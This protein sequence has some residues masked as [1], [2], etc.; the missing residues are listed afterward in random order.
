[1]DAR[2]ALD[3]LA[4]LLGVARSYVDGLGRT[5]QVPPETLSAICRSMGMPMEGP[6]DAPAALAHL[7][8]E[9]AAGPRIPSVIVAWE[10]VLPR[11]PLRTLAPVRAWIECDDGPRVPLE[12]LAGTLALRA[13]RLPIGR[14]TLHVT[15]GDTEA[16]AP[17]L[18]APRLGWRP[19]RSRRRWGVATHVAALRSRRSGAIGD[20]D[21]LE[22]VA[23]VVARHGGDIVTALPLL[24]TFN[25]PPAEPSPYSPVSRLFW[26]EL[27]IGGGP[28]AAAMPHPVD[29]LDVTRADAEIRARL[30]AEPEPESSQLSPELER[31]ARFRGAQVTLG[32]DWRQWP[33]EAR[34]GTL[35]DDQI[36]A[37]EARFHRVAQHHAAARTDR[38]RS[39]FDHLGVA[40]GLDLAVGVHPDGYDPWSRQHLFASGMS[41]GAPPDPGFPSGQDWGFAPI[42]P[43]ASRLEG[44][45]YLARTIAHQAALA[46]VLRIDHIMALSRLY[47]VPHGIDLHRGTYVRYPLDELLAVLVLESH[48][49][50]CELVGENLGTVP[51]EIDE[52]LPRHGIKG[53]RLAL[54]E[55]GAPEPAP[56][57]GDEVAMIDTHD[58]P[59]FAGWLEGRDID[60]R[61]ESKL[62]AA[63]D[64]PAER[65][66]RAEAVGRLAGAVGADPDDPGDFLDRVLDWLARSDSPMLI[67]W[68][69]DLWDEPEQVNLP[70]T[71][72]SVRPNWQR[73]MSG[74]LDDLLAD[75]RVEARLRLIDD[76]R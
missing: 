8:A 66:A 35:R 57:T 36:D 29:R 20:L 21:D 49:H 75:P 74:W 64:A 60:A 42:L 17:V 33:T 30:A 76:A 55:A 24:P 61:V 16:R 38:L 39:A 34:S 65:E 44:H 46:G 70:G 6:G 71:A 12:L 43:E 41:V 15:V 13:V 11:F 3:R 19:A 26:S 18:S 10:G 32:R 37:D 1:M 23:R 9:R 52:A 56:P 4:D 25:T 62:L 51:R 68:L 14:H 67:A 69:E 45:R 54:F 73:P 22:T 40:L 48:R 59:T 53:M 7:R 31:Y 28:R 5:V 72:S 47:W 50:G 58:T 63:E 27:V 2:T